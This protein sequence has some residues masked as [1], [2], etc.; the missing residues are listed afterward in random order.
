MPETF[1]WVR[2]AIRNLEVGVVLGSIVLSYG[3]HSA[4]NT[5]PMV[6]GQLDNTLSRSEVL[7]GRDTLWA[8]ISQEVERELVVWEVH[9]VDLLHPKQL[10]ESDCWS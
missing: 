8:I 6:V 9:V 3:L 7:S 5:L 4:M 10:I 1:P 2:I